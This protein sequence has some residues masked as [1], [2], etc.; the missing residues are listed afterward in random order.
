MS[1]PR[2]SVLPWELPLQTHCQFLKFD[3]CRRK[4]LLKRARLLWAVIN[5]N[6]S[7]P[8]DHWGTTVGHNVLLTVRTSADLTAAARGWLAPTTCWAAVPLGHTLVSPSL[9]Q[10]PCL[11]CAGGES[12]AVTFEAVCATGT[13]FVLVYKCQSCIKL[14]HAAV[15]Q[16]CVRSDWKKTTILKPAFYIKQSFFLC[17][18]VL[19][20]LTALCITHLMFL[21]SEARQQMRFV[22]WLSHN[23][24]CFVCTLPH[25]D[26][27]KNVLD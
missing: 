24:V 15:P 26:D 10:G 27:D 18:C 4:V 11:F 14:T 9:L 13:F 19:S 1:Q 23:G 6:T 20:A 12:G 17:V 2:R 8:R 25:R 3:Y 22:L 21:A 7:P 5:W 16:C